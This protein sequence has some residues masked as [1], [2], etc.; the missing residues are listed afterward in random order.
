MANQVDFRIGITKYTSAH[1]QG[2]SHTALMNHL[3]KVLHAFAKA[4][5]VKQEWHLWNKG[6]HTILK[7]MTF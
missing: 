5:R 1:I 3:N 6:V 2:C 4:S 7:E